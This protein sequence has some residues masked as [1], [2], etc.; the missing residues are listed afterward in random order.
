LYKNLKF[1][2]YCPFF[3]QNLT[4]VL[5]PPEI[6]KFLEKEVIGNTAVSNSFD[7]DITNENIIFS[8]HV[9][10]LSHELITFFLE[11]FVTSQACTSCA[12]DNIYNAHFN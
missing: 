8:A 6:T 9:L 3:V 10:K 12:R 1:G 7:Y 4:S 5:F 2:I 11:C